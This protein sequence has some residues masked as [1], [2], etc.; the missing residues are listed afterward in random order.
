MSQIVFRKYKAGIGVNEKGLACYP[1]KENIQAALE[2]CRD[3]LRA[4][5][6]AVESLFGR[7]VCKWNPVVVFICMRIH[8]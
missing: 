4:K 2:V 1:I 8:Q 7:V 5:K 6:L 3:A